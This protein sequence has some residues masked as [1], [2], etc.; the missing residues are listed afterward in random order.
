MSIITEESFDERMRI[1]YS[2]PTP[3]VQL[4][5]AHRLSL[6]KQSKL[7]I[8]LE[9][10]G[11]DR[12]VMLSVDSEDSVLPTIRSR[13]VI[14]TKIPKYRLSQ[15]EEFKTQIFLQNLF[16]G[17]ERFESITTPDDARQTAYHLRQMIV[18]EIE[19]R[20]MKPPKRRLPGSD[21]DLSTLMK[22]LERFLADPATH[23]LRLLL[24]GFS[25]IPIQSMR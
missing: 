23:N 21:S 13:S 22:V 16:Q 25:M 2:Y 4:Q 3:V 19:A 9:S 11:K 17:K 20:M 24:A 7:L 10:I 5:E 15:D 6:F 14:F 8:W 1:I 12:L 18:G